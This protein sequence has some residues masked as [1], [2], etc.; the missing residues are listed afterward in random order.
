MWD[1]RFAAC[2]TALTLA[3]KRMDIVIDKSFLDGAPTDQVHCLCK[4]ASVLFSEALFFELLTTSSKSQ[5]R[6]FSKFP[7]TPNPVLLI[8]NVGTM[9]RYE[10]ENGTSCTPLVQHKISE[11]FQFNDK[12]RQ[13]TYVPEGNVLQTLKEWEAQV[14]AD[15]EEFLV[16]CSIVHQFF[17]ELNGIEYKKLQS[18]IDGARKRIAEDYDLVR[19]I[20]KSFLEEDAPS[21]AP[22]PDLIGPDWVFFRWVQ[23]QIL[24]ALRMFGKYQGKIELPASERIFTR[25]EHTMH[26]I[27]YTIM[28]TLSGALA[29]GDQEII[30]DFL[31]ACPEGVLVKKRLIG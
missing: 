22:N 13:G 30:D 18:E 28:A 4:E 14:K 7:A 21:N 23:C 20:Y 26:D 25:A 16:R 6:C 1:A 3:L 12:L 11:N 19:S 15:T 10:L 9:L 27:Y 5:K 2:P 29:T 8:P 17:P 31:L 24:S